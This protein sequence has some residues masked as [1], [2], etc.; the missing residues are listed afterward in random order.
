MTDKKNKLTPKQML[1]VSKY[2]KLGV[3]YLAA[4]EA[5]YKG[6]DEA[7][8]V[9]ASRLLSNVKVVREI[10]KRQA[11][12][13]DRLELEEDF[14]AK[15]S[16]KILMTAL[17]DHDLRNANTAVKTLAQIRGKLVQKVQVD[18]ASGLAEE[19]GLKNDSDD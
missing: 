13:N 17:E 6:S 10:E 11:K 7:L 14:E 4:K 16:H 1:F 3:G 15:M 5:G 12:R 19:L 2:V 9:T 18:F 8:M